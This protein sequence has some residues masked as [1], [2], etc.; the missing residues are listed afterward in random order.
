MNE[1]M[2]RCLAEPWA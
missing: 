1:W 2:H